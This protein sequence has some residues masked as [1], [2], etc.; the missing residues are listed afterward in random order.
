MHLG[1]IAAAL[2]RT[3]SSA[4]LAATIWASA[5]ALA[6]TRLLSLAHYL[7]DVLGGMALGIAIEAAVA[8]IT[9]PRG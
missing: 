3:T 2:S 4:P 5:L 1:A 8:R 7:S 9:K 6:G